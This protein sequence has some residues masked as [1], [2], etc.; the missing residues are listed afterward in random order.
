LAIGAEEELIRYVEEEGEALPGI[1]VETKNPYIMVKYAP[2][3]RERIAEGLR[4]EWLANSI[5]RGL[6]TTG[7][8][9]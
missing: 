5:V 8:E 1:G 6:L 4:Q 7:E 2:K 9:A 3:G